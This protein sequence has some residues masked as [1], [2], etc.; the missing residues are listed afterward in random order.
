MKRQLAILLSAAMVLGS[1]VTAMA[2]DVTFRDL[3]DVP[4]EGAK[5]Y[6][7]QAAQLDLMVGEIS[8]DQ[9]TYRF[10]AKDH[11]TYCEAVQLAYNIVISQ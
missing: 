7:L 9:T 11:V 4:W 6:I 2:A 10:R 8:E 1:S 5:N 3:N